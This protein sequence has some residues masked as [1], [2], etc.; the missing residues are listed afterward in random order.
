MPLSI[1]AAPIVPHHIKKYG[2]ET[3]VTRPLDTEPK[4]SNPPTSTS[5]LVSLIILKPMNIITTPPTKPIKVDAKEEAINHPKPANIS[6]I[7]KTSP[8]T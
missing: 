2:F 3:L 6:K 8:I 7:I 1:N 4:S 5:R